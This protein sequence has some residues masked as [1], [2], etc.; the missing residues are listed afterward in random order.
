MQYVGEWMGWKS[1][2][3]YPFSGLSNTCLYARSKLKTDGAAMLMLAT[4]SR[5][6]VP[7][8]HKARS[9]RKKNG[10]MQR[11]ERLGKGFQAFTE[12]A[13]LNTLNR[14]STWYWCSERLISRGQ[15]TG[16][17]RNR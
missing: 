8:T 3:V 6:S 5:V 11:C 13:L 16:T 14:V 7:I 4:L 2:I 15:G 1:F 12:T 9:T 10:E 17:F